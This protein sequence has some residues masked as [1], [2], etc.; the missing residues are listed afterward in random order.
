MLYTTGAAAV[1]GAPDRGRLAA[2]AAGDLVALDVDPLSA[3]PEACREGSV[4]ATVSGG[5]LV[6]DAR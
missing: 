4:L 3:S 2:G 1:A 5:E 6:Y